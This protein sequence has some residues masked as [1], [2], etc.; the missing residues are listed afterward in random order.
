MKSLTRRCMFCGFLAFILSGCTNNAHSER[1]EFM[2]IHTKYTINGR[3]VLGTYGG[4]SLEELRLVKEVGMNLV[5]GGGELLDTT[6]ERGRFCFENGIKVMYSLAGHVHGSPS[7]F[8]D[9]TAGQNEIRI[10]YGKPYPGPALVQIDDEM[11][12]YQSA[13]DTTLLGCER[14]AHGT[15]AAPHH[16][17]LILVWPEKVEESV[18]Q[19]MDSPNL[20]GY[21]V[22]DDSPGAAISALRGVYRVVKR[23]DPHNHP[24]CGG[25]S[26]GTTLHNFAADAADVIM[27]YYYPFLKWEYDR[28]MTSY[29][30]QWMLTAARKKSPGVE[31][32][33]IYQGFWGGQWNQQHPLSPEDI[34][35]QVE[36][37][38]RDGASG[39]I[40]FYIGSA[41]EQNFYGW[42]VEEPLKREIQAIN[43][44][45]TQTGGLKI[46]PEPRFMADMRFQ[47]KGYWEHPQDV[48][49]IPPAWWVL[50][51]FDDPEKKLLATSFPPEQGIDLNASYQGKG[52]TIHWRKIETCAGGIGLVETIGPLSFLFHSVAY[53]T[54]EVT[55]PR[56]QNVQMRV[57]SGHDCIIWVDGLQV[58]RFDGLRGVHWDSNMVTMR[59]KKGK[60]RI[61]V[62]VCD[63]EGQWGFFVRFT[64]RSG[65]PL[66]GLTFS[67]AQDAG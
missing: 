49:G 35:E 16:A 23:V 43:R 46:N 14:G 19:V 6:S 13:N 2:R 50:A 45:I 26:G 55:S 37:F 67:P 30:T 24:V 62:K 47:P 3:P 25:Y 22:I 40:S 21:Y 58:Y 8:D 60:N 65:K 54:C 52:R 7:L 20:F 29:D 5:F 31:L 1:D 10:H 57:G 28:T 42:Q 39:I 53:A 51:P 36:D 15:A 56:D 9:I 12:R 11:I 41:P 64:D 33:G 66:E 61:L 48:P 63:Q 38:V 18:R 59:L 34:R 44:E 27:A 4:T 32:F 17:G